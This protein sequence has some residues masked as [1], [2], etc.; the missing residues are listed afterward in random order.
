MA[1]GGEEGKRV[2]GVV[3]FKPNKR[4]PGGKAT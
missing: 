2:P 4:V 3:T 1:F